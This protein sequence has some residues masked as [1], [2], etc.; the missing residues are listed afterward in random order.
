MARAIDMRSYGL[1]GDS[2]VDVDA[3]GAVSLGARRVVPLALLAARFPA[4]EAALAVQLE[5]PDPPRYPGRFVL[6][7]FASVQ[8]TLPASSQF[9]LAVL[10]P[11]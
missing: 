5:S 10:V 4:V 2:E 6:A 11:I 9:T 7:P 3:H 8:T 1:G